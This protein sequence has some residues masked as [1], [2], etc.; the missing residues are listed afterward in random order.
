MGNRYLKQHLLARPHNSV[1]EAVRIS[2]EFCEAGN[3]SD[4][5]I[6]AVDTD[7]PTTEN[8]MMKI[9]KQ[10]QELMTQQLKVLTQILKPPKAPDARKLN[11]VKGCYHC[12]GPHLK[13]NCP[14]IAKKT[15]SKAKSTSLEGNSMGPAQ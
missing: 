2:E 15:A 8:E 9:L 14:E 5:K 13:R 12:G 11:A 1:T 4:T 10:M 3:L 6:T 7:T